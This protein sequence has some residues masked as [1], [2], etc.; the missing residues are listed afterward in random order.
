MTIAQREARVLALEASIEDLTERI[1]NRKD[2]VSAEQL[3]YWR[4]KRD[5]WR[6]QLKEHKNILNGGKTV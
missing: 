2:Y 4:K 1:T 5:Q 3:A 6:R